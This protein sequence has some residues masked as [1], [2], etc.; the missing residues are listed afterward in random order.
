MALYLHP[1]TEAQLRR[2]MAA[3]PQALLLTGKAGVGLDTIARHIASAHSLL[4][5]VQPQLLSK[6]ATIPQISIEQIRDLYTLSRGKRTSAAVIIIDDG[7]KMSESAQNS[8][9]KLLEEPPALVHFI[10]TTHAPE[11][12]LPTVRSR[13]QTLAVR[14][15][16]ASET[17]RLLDEAALEKT[18]R[19]QLEFIASG[20][21]A[22]LSR[23]I[24]D[25]A[26]FAQRSERVRLARQLIEAPAGERLTTLQR[27][28]L[29]RD[30]A[31]ALVRQ[32]IALVERAA[33]SG[34][35]E[36]LKKLLGALERIEYGGNIRLQLALG[37]L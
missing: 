32:M 28:S 11:Q 36:R 22:E 12:L 19:Q 15:L 16:P 31:A 29:N 14:P 2:Y 34:S 13:L 9:L 33:Q 23:L 1:D 25:E 8:L 3:L 7:D 5:R 24:R 10:L 17:K 30:E 21:P 4:A 20:L 6:T 35:P 27:Q 26:Y 37:I 18:K